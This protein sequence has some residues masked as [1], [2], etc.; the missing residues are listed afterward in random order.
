METL[1]TAIKQCQIC[2]SALELGCRPVVQAH[3]NAKLLIIGQA[4]GIKVHQSGV[5]FNDASGERLRLWLGMDSETFYDPTKVAIMPMGF[6]YPGKGKSGDLPPR[7]ECAPQWHQALLARLPNIEM[8]LLIG[9]YA[10]NY[11]LSNSELSGSNLGDKP[12]TLTETVKNWQ[13]WAPSYVP[14]PH[15]SPRNN[16]WL[17]KNP[18]F[19]QDVIPYIQALIK[20]KIL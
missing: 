16:I 19:E 6:C 18:W 9:Q 12:K 7:K 20:T 14:I 13:Q 11:Y 8:T 17:K 3:P 4:P 15:P 10:Q 1:L 2:E 5:P